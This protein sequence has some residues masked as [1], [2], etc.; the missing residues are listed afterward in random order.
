MSLIGS[1]ARLGAC[2]AVAGAAGWAG[3]AS[4]AWLRYGRTRDDFG[5]VPLLDGVMPEAEVDE[6]HQVH[7]AAPAD[8]TFDAAC[9]LDLQASPVN[10]AIM[11]IRTLP[12]RFRGDPVRAD[13][14]DGLLAETLALGW[15]R[16]AEDPGRE[17]VMG[18]VTQPWKGE[19]VFRPVPPEEFAAFNEPGFAKITWTLSVEPTGPDTCVFRTRTRVMTTD[20]DSRQQFRRYWAMFSPGILLIRYE[21]LRLLKAAAERGREPAPVA[22]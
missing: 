3:Y 11:G 19:A 22:A 14:S 8:V 6:C 17:L 9:R 16:L 20:A 2:A 7:V 5:Q 15:G 13:A 18:A 21:V 12:A 4:L 1:A 10:A